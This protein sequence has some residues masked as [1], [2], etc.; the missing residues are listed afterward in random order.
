MRE[1]GVAADEAEAR[2]L[3]H[4]LVIEP[5][6]VARCTGLVETEVNHKISVRTCDPHRSRFLSRSGNSVTYDDCCD[7]SESSN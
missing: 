3:K 6:G 5:D 1:I 2:F 7:R 4:R